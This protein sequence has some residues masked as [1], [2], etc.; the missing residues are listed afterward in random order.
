MNSVWVKI[1]IMARSLEKILKESLRL[2]FKLSPNKNACIYNTEEPTD[3]PIVYMMATNPLI[4]LVSLKID[5][6][7]SMSHTARFPN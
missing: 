5:K 7:K 4:N 2:T 6:V 3:N 1:S